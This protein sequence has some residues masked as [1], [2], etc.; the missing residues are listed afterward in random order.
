MLDI[1][2]AK[3][4]VLLTFDF[5]AESAEVRKTP[6]LPVKLSKGQFGPR[7]GI[8][9]IFEFLKKHNIKSTFFVPGWTADHYPQETRDILRDGHEIAAHGYLHENFS[10]MT[11]RDEWRALRKSVDSLT[12]VVG[13]KPAGFRAPYWDWSNRTLGYLGKIGF[14]YDSS[15]MSDDKPFTIAEEHSTGGMCELPVE[16]FLDDWP[17]F[18]IQHQSPS[19]VLD[20]WRREFNAVY[21]TTKYF[22]LTMHPECI[23][24]ASRI[25]MLDELVNEISH[26]PD[27]V[28]SRC[29]EFVEALHKRVHT[30]KTS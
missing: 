4:V 14:M 23:G 18:E 12:R 16:N 11:G 26:R 8:G 5:D 29:D 17:L 2:N 3:C 10:E 30:D 7:V 20:S 24:R 9:R 13:V 25:S 1:T 21:S 22:M 6:D 27:V 15:L 19:N 28:F